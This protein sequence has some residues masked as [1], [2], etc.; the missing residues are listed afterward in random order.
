MQILLTFDWR[1][2]V[3]VFLSDAGPQTQLS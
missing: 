1:A 3:D 2:G